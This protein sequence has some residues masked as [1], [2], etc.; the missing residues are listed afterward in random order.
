MR[1]HRLSC[2]WY[3][4]LP[5][6][7]RAPGEDTDYVRFCLQYGARVVLGDI[8]LLR[9]VSELETNVDRQSPEVRRFCEVF[10][11]DRMVATFH[12]YPPGKNAED[13]P[14]PRFPVDGDHLRDVLLRVQ[15][16]SL[17][18]P[19]T[20]SDTIG[21]ALQETVCMANHSCVPN[22]AIVLAETDGA[23]SFANVWQSPEPESCV[24]L[25]PS[26]SSSP[27][28]G[29]LAG[30]MGLISTRDIRKGEEVTISYVD[31]ESFGGDG[32]ARMKH[33]L[34]QYRFLCNCSLCQ[35]QRSSH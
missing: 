33:L 21:W 22:A 6:S 12:A 30:C 23:Q 26:S 11:R 1:V 28:D 34:T 14:V 7:V 18:F 17:G 15:C 4:E 9:S 35:S 29:L 10:A 25:S 19:F 3:N 2:A 13:Y 16:N 27:S 8:P 20:A 24:A 31:V 32:K 5:A